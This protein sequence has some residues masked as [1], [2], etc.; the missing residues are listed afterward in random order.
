[1]TEYR[2]PAVREIKKRLA[3]GHRFEAVSLFAGGGGS[4]TG[5]R[6]AGGKILAINE[7]VPEAVKTYEANW[8][9]TYIFTQDVRDLTAGAILEQIRK[10]PGELDLLDGSPPCS[11]FSSA[12][13]REKLWGKMKVYS[14]VHQKGVETLFFEY[15][16]ILDGIRPKVFVA[17]NVAGL[18]RGVS[19]GFLREFLAAF[20]AKGYVVH[21]KI[22]DAK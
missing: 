20:R 9:E 10:Q 5:Y 21:A 19:R 11:A 15:V 18:A 7:F 16:R 12:G 8:P 14:D 17:E 4:S 22:L 6:M 1:M 3:A 13:K 2:V